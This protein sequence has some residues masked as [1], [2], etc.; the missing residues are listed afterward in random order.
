MRSDKTR[1]DVRRLQAQSS[2]RVAVQ[3]SSELIQFDREVLRAEIQAAMY[4]QLKQHEVERITEVIRIESKLSF[5]Q[6]VSVAL[7]I[8]ILSLFSALL[9]LLLQK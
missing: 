4:T 1:S 2:R 5:W 7:C 9:V 8:F 3:S 6:G